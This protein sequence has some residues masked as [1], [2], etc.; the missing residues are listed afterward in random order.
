MINWLK[1]IGAAGLYFLFFY[2]FWQFLNW[3]Q[4]SF[5]TISYILIGFGFL[6]FTAW[7]RFTT[8]RD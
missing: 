6:F 4:P 1:A 2:L 5:E 8:F 3:W 7:F